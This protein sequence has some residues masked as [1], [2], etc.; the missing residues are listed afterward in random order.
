MTEGE[1]LKVV[2]DLMRSFDRS[3]F[4]LEALPRYTSDAE[5]ETIRSYLAGDPLPPRAS[6]PSPYEGLVGAAKASGKEW[7]RVHAF[8][9]PPNTYLR[10]E[11]DWHYVYNARAGEDIRILQT[12]DLTAVF[13]GQ[14]P[15]F[16]LFDDSIGVEMAYDSEYRLTGVELV[17]GSAEVA[18]YRA[19]RDVALR[20]AVT[21]R[22]YLAALRR[23][24]VPA[25]SAPVSVG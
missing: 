11:I 23:Q 5:T 1:M 25:M 17:T 2:Y 9:G 3:V 21:L 12:E 6:A 19:L 14:P 10:Y 24:V 13:G 8:E 15:D 18:R 7:A 4:R 22:E 16:W 20:E